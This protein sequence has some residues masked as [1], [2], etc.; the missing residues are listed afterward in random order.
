M[1]IYALFK[2]SPL[3]YNISMNKLRKEITKEQ[4]I[5]Y[6][7]LF[8]IVLVVV[9]NANVVVL[10]IAEIIRHYFYIMGWFMLLVVIIT[11]INTTYH[12]YKHR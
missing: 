5:A 8:G 4:L 6:Y 7:M 11:F 3:V 10:T 12:I 2:C 1:S 9:T